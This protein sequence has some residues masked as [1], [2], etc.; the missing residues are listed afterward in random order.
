MKISLVWIDKKWK[1]KGIAEN[2]WLNIYPDTKGYRKFTT[3]FINTDA[4][5]TVEV[6]RKSD[7]DDMI[8]HLESKGYQNVDD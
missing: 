7:I 4:N 2:V 1:H 3:P 8:K 6:V 5:N